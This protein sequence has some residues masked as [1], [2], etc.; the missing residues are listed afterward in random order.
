MAF[1]QGC[2]PGPK[3]LSTETKSIGQLIAEGAG[4][5]F[6]SM[7]EYMQLLN[8]IEM[9]EINGLNCQ[10]AKTTLIIAIDEMKKSE[11]TYFELWNNSLGLEYNAEIVLRLRNFNYALFQSEKGLNAEIFRKVEKYLSIGDVKGVYKQ[12]YT[13]TNHISSML[14]NLKPM[15]DACLFNTEYLWKINQRFLDTLLFGQYIAQVFNEIKK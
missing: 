10:E 6:T 11:V 5:Y 15:A 2:Y 7:A 14:Q 8:K 13:D 4:H 1:Q 12:F 3:V 9:S